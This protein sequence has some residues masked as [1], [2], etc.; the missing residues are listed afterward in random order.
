MHQLSSSSPVFTRKSIL[1][2]SVRNVARRGRQY[3]DIVCTGLPSRQGLAVIA[4]V[5]LNHA[6]MV[7]GDPAV[8]GMSVVDGCSC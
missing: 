4:T 6:A 1:H 8:A 3:W 7:Y 2:L 5:A